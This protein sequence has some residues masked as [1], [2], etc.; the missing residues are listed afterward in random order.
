MASA[1][2]LRW[3]SDDHYGTTPRRRVAKQ[4]TNPYASS[5]STAPHPRHSEP[6]TH[7][8]TASSRR[9]RVQRGPRPRRI[10]GGAVTTV[11][12]FAQL[13]VP[14][15]V[16]PSQPLVA[17]QPPWKPQLPEL[18]PAYLQ[19]DEDADGGEAPTTG[20]GDEGFEDEDKVEL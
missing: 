2:S 16:T 19:G 6:N 17:G 14:T 9:R 20:G 5:N 1:A 18:E 12:S 3:P 7:D 11:A 13:G 8:L 10:Q 15:P 4:P